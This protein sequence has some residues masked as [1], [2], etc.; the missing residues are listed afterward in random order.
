MTAP[1]IE[2]NHGSSQAGEDLASALFRLGRSKQ[3]RESLIGVLRDA[4][5]LLQNPGVNVREVITGPIVDAL[6]ERDELLQ[7]EIEGGLRFNFRYT[8]KIARDFVMANSPDHVWEPQTTKLLVKLG[9]RAKIAIIAGAYLG[10]QA[11]P[12]ASAMK[13]NG[14]ICY[15]FEPNK[16]Q[17]ELLESNARINDIT[18]L[19][20]IRRGLWDRDDVNLS[21]VGDDNSLSF[22]RERGVAEEGTFKSVS[23]ERFA[24]EHNIATIDLMMLDT[25]GGELAAVTGAARFLQQPAGTAPNI[26]FEIHG[27]YTDWSR[28]LENTEIA[29][30]LE[31]LG[32]HLY[33]IRDY[34]GNV[35]MRGRPIELVPIRT[36][37]IAGPSH[38]FNIFAVK[39]VKVLRWLDVRQVDKVSPK[40]L[41]HRDPKLHQPID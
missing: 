10:D 13:N 28:G 12:L 19:I 26:I 18:N 11:V 39:D 15:C 17:F 16:K 20:A 1:K 33:G 7:K 21:L 23:V 6:F 8:S 30:Y 32:Y 36:A 4:E 22:S 29:R 31:E 27:T 14:G 35:D 37:Y 41:F 34:Q 3:A 2:V 38:G 5:A 25:E 24:S 9:S 40:L